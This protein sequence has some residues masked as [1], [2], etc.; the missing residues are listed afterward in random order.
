MPDEIVVSMLDKMQKTIASLRR[1]YGS[2][3]AGRATPQL[4]DR[5]T[6][7]YYG[8]E[9]PLNQVANISIPEARIIQ[10]APW[11]QKMIT[12][13]EKAIQKSDLGINPNNDGKVIR[14]ILPEL[15]QERRADLAKQAAKLAEEA[16]VAVRAIRRDANEL[17]KKQLKSNEMTEDDQKDI[18][19]DI[20]KS[21]DK[22]IK[23]IDQVAAEKEKELM[24]I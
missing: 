13:I 8:T 6:V 16:K 1:E 9:T 19:S 10:I 22:I 18:E 5:I 20:Q 24:S 4:L 11:E 15:T 2:M 7:D 23:E 17:V 14:L 21:T 12:P 3:R